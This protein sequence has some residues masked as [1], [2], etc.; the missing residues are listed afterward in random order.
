[1]EERI[2]RLN[3]TV[4]YKYLDK[5]NDSESQ[6]MDYCDKYGKKNPHRNRDAFDSLIN[7]FSVDNN[8]YDPLKGVI[9]VNQYGFLLDGQH[10]ACLLLKKYG[11]KKKIPVLKIKARMSVRRKLGLLFKYAK[12]IFGK[13]SPIIQ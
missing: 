11:P 1:M 8:D 2:L 4:V 7:D 5:N 9:I 10:R 6:Y 13:K 3:E 12:M